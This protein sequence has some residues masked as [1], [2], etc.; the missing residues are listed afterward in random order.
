[1]ARRVFGRGPG[2]EG[3]KRPLGNPIVWLWSGYLVE[4]KFCLVFYLFKVIIQ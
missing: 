1:M 2:E 3:G 4:Y